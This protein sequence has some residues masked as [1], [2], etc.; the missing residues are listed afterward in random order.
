[1]APGQ[2]VTEFAHISPS[3]ERCPFL[4][5]LFDFPAAGLGNGN[6]RRC[7][8]GKNVGKGLEK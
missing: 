1:M 4:F 8:I 7:S 2:L 5:F 6:S 3:L